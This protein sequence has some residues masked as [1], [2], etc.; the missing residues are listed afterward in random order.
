MTKS[1]ALET[2]YGK[3]EANRAINMAESIIHWD[4]L[5]SGVP[6]LSLPARGA[7][8]GWLKE[9]MYKHCMSMT[10]GDLMLQATG[11]P[12]NAKYYIDYL[13]EKFTALYL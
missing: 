4:A 5:T 10:P 3:I 11:E 8:A 1:Q 9:N 2:L 13:S 6:V 7:S 12:F